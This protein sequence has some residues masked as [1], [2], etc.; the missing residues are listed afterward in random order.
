MATF[1]DMQTS[2]SKR[3]LDANNTAVSVSDVAASINDSV[4]YWKFR[5]FWFNQIVDSSFMI[6]NIAVIP[7]PS[8]FLVPFEDDDGFQI[9]YGN[10]RY[11][12]AK[13]TTQEY[14]GLW[15]ANG[16]GLPRW[17]ARVGQDYV[18][19]PIPDRNYVIR[20][21]Y[22][23]EYVDLVEANDENDFSVY[24]SRLIILWSCANLIAEF[25]QDDK[26]ETYFRGAAND[27]YRQ[28]RVMTDKANGSGKLSRS[29]TLL[30]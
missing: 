22:L 7:L 9:E 6:E 27:E 29:S 1:G 15:V 11:P 3:L 2:V 24:A 10:T 8:D 5:R 30:N 17:Y 18:T 19:W 23:K 13:L 16:N 14:D 21:N 25:R 20:R 26:M 4:R 12:L 28:L